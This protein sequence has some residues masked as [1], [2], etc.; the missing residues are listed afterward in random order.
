MNSSKYWDLIIRPKRNL[1]A[2]PIAEL[3]KYK[4]LI[5]MFVRRDFVSVYKADHSGTAVVPDPATIDDHHLHGDFLVISPN[6]PRMAYRSFC[7]ICPVQ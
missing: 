5:G 1:F 7:S 6:C 3:W 2:L 4:D